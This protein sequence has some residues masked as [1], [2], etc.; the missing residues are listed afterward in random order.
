MGHKTIK[1]KGKAALPNFS[2]AM[3]VTLEDLE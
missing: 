3:V 2:L 1:A